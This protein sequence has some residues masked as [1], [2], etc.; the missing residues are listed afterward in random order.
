VYAGGELTALRRWASVVDAEEECDFSRAVSLGWDLDAKIACTEGTKVACNEAKAVATKDT[1]RDEDSQACR[2]FQ[3]GR[4]RFA[5]SCKFSHTETSDA[6]SDCSVTSSMT[7]V[8]TSTSS[9]KCNKLGHTSANCPEKT[10]RRQAKAAQGPVNARSNVPSSTPRVSGKTQQTACRDYKRGQCRRGNSCK[11][12]HVPA[13]MAQPASAG[14][15]WWETM[16]H[17][18]SAT[19]PASTQPVARQATKVEVRRSSNILGVLSQD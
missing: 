5:A 11:Y 19:K 16:S 12:S 9:G 15:P 14:K 3:R 6:A 13:T 17:D 1:C 2:D 7:T 4:C 18:K 10:T 8:S